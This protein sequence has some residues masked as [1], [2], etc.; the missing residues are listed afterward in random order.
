MVPIQML[1]AMLNEHQVSEPENLEAGEGSAE[2]LA[3]FEDAALPLGEGPLALSDIQQM[4]IEQP[5]ISIGSSINIPPP[6]PEGGSDLPA[7]GTGSEPEVT[8]PVL[9]ELPKQEVARLAPPQGSDARPILTEPTAPEFSAR[10][11]TEGPQKRGQHLSLAR[12]Y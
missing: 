7:N 1:S 3:L 5:A 6:P 9:R 8:Q 11:L 2:F 10:I 4:A 12:E